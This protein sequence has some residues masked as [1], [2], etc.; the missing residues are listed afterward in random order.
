[1]LNTRVQF[2]FI[3]S[4]FVRANGVDNVEEVISRTEQ[5]HEAHPVLSS[6]NLYSIHCFALIANSS[7]SPD[8]SDSS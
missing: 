5:L 8:R 3:L 1:M 6:V 7:V 2:G 4:P